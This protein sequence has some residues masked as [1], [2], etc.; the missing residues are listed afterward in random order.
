MWLLR[1]D[2]LAG[3]FYEVKCILLETTNI[4]K[5]SSN[6]AR[7]NNRNLLIV[8][9]LVELCGAHTFVTLN[10]QLVEIIFNF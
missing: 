6:N 8:P 3:E 10:K 7:L 2:A 4:Y 1:E 5:N 9:N